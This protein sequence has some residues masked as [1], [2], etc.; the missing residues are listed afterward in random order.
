MASLRRQYLE[1]L[2]E[3]LSE[4]DGVHA[5][6]RSGEVS[7]A[8]AEWLAVVFLFGEDKRPIDTMSYACTMRVGV[9]VRVRMENATEVEHDGNPWNLLDEKVADVER[10]VHSAEWPD[11]AIVTLTGH[12]TAP[13]AQVG[14]TPEATVTIE[15]Q[16]RHDWADPDTPTGV[17]S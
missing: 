6:L 8:D 7:S 12:A 15:V 9:L 17:A 1:Q 11:D 14:N 5:T 13:P 2:V 16:Y 10:A 3:Q 4:L